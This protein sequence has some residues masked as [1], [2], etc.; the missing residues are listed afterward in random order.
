MCIRDSLYAGNLTDLGAATSA[1]YGTSVNNAL[2]AANS[3]ISADNTYTHAISGGGA[4][5]VN[6]VDFELLDANTTP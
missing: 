2:T 4:E 3:G 6:G 5:T 1:E